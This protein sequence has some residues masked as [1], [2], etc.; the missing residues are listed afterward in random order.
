MKRKISITVVLFLMFS[1]FGEEKFI[2][3]DLGRSAFVNDD[4]VRVRTLDSLNSETISLLNKGCVCK[5]SSIGSNDYIGKET[6]N[7]IFIEYDKQKY[8]WIWGKYISFVDQ[9]VLDKCNE[10]SKD[11]S[12]FTSDY[13]FFYEKGIFHYTEILKLF[14]SE[15]LFRINKIEI[16]LDKDS[17]INFI[18]NLENL[19]DITLINGTV[20]DLQFKQKKMY[21]LNFINCEIG[22]LD[23]SD[24]FLIG[25]S[26]ESCRKVSDSVIKYPFEID[27]VCINNCNFYKNE[28]SR[29]PL[30]IRELYLCN[31]SI[32]EYS[33]LKELDRYKEL[34]TLYLEDN[35]ILEEDRLRFYQNFSISYSTEL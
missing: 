19:N 6:N 5:I 1:C 11:C 30:N 3:Q 33:F 26:F 8:G 31:N 2:K 22:N 4:R 20:L 14:T 17:Q 28:L 13:E 16:L 27:F 25:L 9:E 18:D 15:Q 12:F 35:P 21:R 7:W 32:S 29:L 34:S 24:I 10:I 23:L